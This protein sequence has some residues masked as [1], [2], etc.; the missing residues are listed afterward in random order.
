[1]IQIYQKWK[2]CFKKINNLCTLC[3][4]LKIIFFFRYHKSLDTFITYKRIRIIINSKIFRDFG[5]Y[6]HLK[7]SL[8]SIYL[9]NLLFK[10]KNNLWVYKLQHILLIYELLYLLINIY[11]IIMSLLRIKHLLIYIKLPEMEKY[12]EI[13]K[14]KVDIT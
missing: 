11:K 1:M 12:L 4:Y 10:K 8:V 13:L 5:N 6:K 9:N 2:I 14:E 3:R 7:I